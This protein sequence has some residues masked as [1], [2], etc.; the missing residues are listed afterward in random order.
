MYNLS[1][2]TFNTQTTYYLKMMP[3]ST[4]IIVYIVEETVELINNFNIQKGLA[5]SS[6]TYDGEPFVFKI[7]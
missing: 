5:L 7:E 3:T 2:I 4:S 1:K 6:H